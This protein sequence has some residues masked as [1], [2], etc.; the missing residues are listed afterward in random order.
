MPLS[1]RSLAL[2]LTVAAAAGQP[3]PRA[4]HD[5]ARLKSLAGKRNDRAAG[6]KVSYEVT[7]GGSVV[8]ETRRPS[9]EPPMVT[10]FHLDRDQLMLTHYSIA[11]PAIIRE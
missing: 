3:K 1:C 10:V 4:A 6:L 5:F 8:I 2:V 11:R 9:N 7:S